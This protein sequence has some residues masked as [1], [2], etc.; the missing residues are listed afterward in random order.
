MGEGGAYHRTL[1]SV[2]MPC[3]TSPAFEYLGLWL[4]VAGL[5][6]FSLMGID[7][8]KAVNHRWRISELTLLTSAAIGG[9]A[10]LVFGSVLFHHKSVKLSFLLVAYVIAAAWVGV[11]YQLG[12]IGWAAG[13]LECPAA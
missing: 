4:A 11:L 1:R 6:A 13:L 12:F 10:G 2:P 9:F 3:L 8:Y 7:K 5:V